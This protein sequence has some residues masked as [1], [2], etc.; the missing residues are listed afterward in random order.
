MQYFIS[1]A[2]AYRLIKAEDLITDPA[3]VVI[4]AVDEFHDSTNRTDEL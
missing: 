3:H 1:K 4:W 2:W